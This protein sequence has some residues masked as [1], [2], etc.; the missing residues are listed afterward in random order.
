MTYL[1]IPISLNCL[2]RTEVEAQI[3]L[4][5]SS[6]FYLEIVW[7]LEWHSCIYVCVYIY[8]HK[9]TYDIFIYLFKITLPELWFDKRTTSSASSNFPLTW[10]PVGDV[11]SQ[12]ITHLSINHSSIFS[13][14]RCS[15]LTAITLKTFL[16]LVRLSD[17]F[18]YST[19]I[20]D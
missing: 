3:I 10:E 19:F 18:V 2:P 11:G 4:K 17:N 9:I 13:S 16:A 20:I 5:L 14:L 12:Q 6:C 7:F 8:K 15:K 1:D